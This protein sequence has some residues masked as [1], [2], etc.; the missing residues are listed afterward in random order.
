MEHFGE[1]LTQGL[2]SI[3]AL[4]NKDLTD[5]QREL[6]RD[7][8]I[9]VWTIYKWRKGKSIPNDDRTIELLARACVQ[10]G[11]MD[12]LWLNSFLYSTIYSN[13][14]A[15]ITD[16]FPGQVT[17]SIVQNLPRCQH[18]RLVGRDHEMNEI[19]KFLSPYHRVGVV[20]ISGGGGIGKSALALEIAHLCYE[21]S[22]LAPAN[23]RFD[24]II[25]ITAK[26]VELL[27]V[28]Q[29][30]RKATFS[31][32][33]SIYRAIAD[34]LD[35]PVIFRTAT[36]S[37]QS[38]IITRLLANKR[39][40]LMLDN[41]EDVDDNELLIFLRDL[42]APSKAIITT[43]HR[44]DVA[45]PIYLHMLDEQTATELIQIECERHKLSMTGDQFKTL[46]RYTGGLPLAII[47]TIGRMAWR[48][49]SIETEI[50][51]LS[52]VENDIYDFCFAKTLALIRRSDAH[53]LFMALS[54][55]AADIDRESLG[56]V[57]GF[58]DNPLRRDEGLSDIEVLSLCYKDG[59]CF[60]LE[61]LTR[62]QALSELL[63]NPQFEE[64]A[65]DRWIL[66]CHNFS[67]HYG[68]RDWME[69]HL[70]YD[71]LEDAWTNILGVL[72][73]C[74]DHSRSED[75]IQ[76]WT[77]LRDFTHIYG[78]WS[79]RLN[80][81]EW[82]IVDAENRDDYATLV[83]LMF[84][85]AFTLTLTGPS[86][87]L[88]EADAL[89]Q[90]CWSLRQYVNLPVQARIA[91]LRASLLIKYDKHNEANQWLD[92]AEDLLSQTD[93]EPVELARER[94]SLLYDRGENWFVMG[95]YEQAY[96]VFLE[97][98]EQAQ[99][100]SWQRST[101][102]AQ[103]WLAYT[104]IFRKMPD[105]CEEY[106]R[107]GWAIASRVKEKRLVAYF[108]RTHAYY[109]AEIGDFSSALEWAEDALDAFERLGMPRDIDMMHDMIK[110]LSESQTT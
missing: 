13:K 46:I 79:D 14:Q 4:E 10:R 1:L 2:K 90:R 40:L 109:Y 70:N 57:A 11:R 77:Q 91:A 18:I 27:P 96:T 17:N 73:W 106:L 80:L 105:E 71:L 85:R 101:L 45:V 30:R 6:G 98:L 49:S 88:E 66:W 95:Q 69:M 32:L 51:H 36:H 54:I 26:S 56:Y 86:T 8:G 68:G 44:I 84:D 59:Q 97:M 19:R 37:Q 3:G 110:A 35:V 24:A 20:C 94:T 99:M 62:T 43:R 29:I 52:N 74:Q 39:V 38:L 15:L 87:R 108:K 92:K 31:D 48:G 41:L 65:R 63:H 75:L 64:Q 72:H 7:I 67:R 78:Y 22:L 25:W 102:H 42:P 33:D 21:E 34:L 93:L 81:L 82:M 50:Q 12:S 28:G 60:G 47:H 107:T 103:N 16:L 53:A 76:L 89:L 58:D 5:L 23:E 100:C 9:S 61:P 83:E 55:F 104:L